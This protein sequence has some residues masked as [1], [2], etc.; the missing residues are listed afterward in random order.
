MYTDLFSVSN[1]ALTNDPFQFGKWLI[2]KPSPGE[3]NHCV[4]GVD[5]TNFPTCQGPDLSHDSQVSQVSLQMEQ[6]A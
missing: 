2:T 1:C 5:D 3:F 6:K 4:G